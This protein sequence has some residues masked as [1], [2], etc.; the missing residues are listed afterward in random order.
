MLTV[1][2]IYLCGILL[3]LCGTY[4]TR[5]YIGSKP[6]WS[7]YYESLVWLLSLIYLIG[8]G[9]RILTSLTSKKNKNQL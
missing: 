7:D 9:I 8:A 4:L 3:Y 2:Y 6:K 5:G 1:L